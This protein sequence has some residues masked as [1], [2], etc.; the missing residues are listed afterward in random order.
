[1]RRFASFGDDREDRVLI[2]ICKAML[3]VLA[4]LCFGLLVPLTMK[5]NRPY[6]NIPHET[7]LRADVHPYVKLIDHVCGGV[8]L[9]C[10]DSMLQY[11]A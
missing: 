5:A 11:L 9:R 10:I 3:S 6:G 4:C 2:P 7:A 8:S 1:V